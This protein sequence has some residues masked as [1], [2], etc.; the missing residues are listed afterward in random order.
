MDVGRRNVRVRLV[1][2]GRRFVEGCEIDWQTIS[3]GVV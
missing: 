2:D 1:G 3:K